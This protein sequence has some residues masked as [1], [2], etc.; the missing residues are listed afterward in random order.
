MDPRFREDDEE[1]KRRMNAWL[2]GIYDTVSEIY[3]PASD[4]TTLLGGAMWASA[5]TAGITEHQTGKIQSAFTGLYYFHAR[6]YDPVVGRWRGWDSLP[7]AVGRAGAGWP[8]P[9]SGGESLSHGYIES[10]GIW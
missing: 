7:G 3:Y 1:G 10:S 4:R 6:F 2:R 9:D 8:E 5:R